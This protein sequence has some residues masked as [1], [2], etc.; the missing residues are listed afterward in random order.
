MGATIGARRRTLT[1][2]RDVRP[3]VLDF[4][5]VVCR[6]TL[7]WL[8]RAFCSFYRRRASGEVPVFPRF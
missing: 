1:E 3:E 7:K 8:D 5:V 2:L 6:G 4:G